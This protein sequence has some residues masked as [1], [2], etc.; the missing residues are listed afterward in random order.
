VDYRYNIRGW[1]K[2]INDVNSLGS[3]LFGFKIGYNEGA[4]ALYNGNISSTSWRTNNTDNSLKQYNYLYDALNRIKSGKD[5]TTNEQYS[6]QNVLY[7]KNG[8][9]T[10]LVRT[11]HLVENPL[12]GNT[13]H[14]GEMDNMY[15][16]YDAGNKLQRV[17]DVANKSYGFKDSSTNGTDYSYDQN[18]N[19][20]SDANKGISNITYNHLNLPIQV[21]MVDGNI[22]YIYDAVGLKLKKIVTNTAESS[23][24]NTEYAGNYIYE[25]GSL[26][27]FNTAEGYVED[28][29]SGGFDYIYQYKDHLGNIRLSY[30]DA[31]GNGV[32]AQ[33]EIREENNYYPFGLKHR[34]YNQYQGAARDHT[35]EYNGSELEESLGF[36]MMEM[37]MR[38]FDPALAR[39]VVLDPV[40][41]HSL[42]P[43]NSF[44]N[45]PIIFA[46]PSG[47]DSFFRSNFLNQKGGH[48][49]DKVFGGDSA[50]SEANNLTPE[51]N[52][53]SKTQEGESEVKDESVGDTDCDEEC[54]RK[55]QNELLFKFRL[56]KIKLLNAQL[57][58]ETEKVA[59]LRDKMMAF[60][61]MLTD[62]GVE[63]LATPEWWEVPL[64]LFGL[65]GIGKYK[66]FL[67]LL[68]LTNKT[69]KFFKFGGDEAI[70]HFGKHAEQIM[71]VTGRSSYNLKDY[72]GDANWII[73]NGTYSSKLN[74]YFYYMGNS[75]KSGE[76]LLGFVGMKYGG[77]T[78]STFHIKSA[79]KLGL[80]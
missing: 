77:N 24:T 56:Y 58:G 49:T 70:I 14:F 16:F 15:Y 41:H 47:A 61:G 35:F 60:G 5:N 45:N 39:W 10:R 32:I 26:Q 46:D 63:Q 36:N 25:N 52:E 66:H 1:L 6:L 68:Q 64:T 55:R 18:G 34:G 37:E 22:Q 29:G 3:D 78:I 21:T 11:G 33:S 73:K 74:G 59:L 4:N 44:D 27:F 54:Q 28:D 7:D 23:L 67:K 80:K 65:G 2:E 8:N 57:R 48:W 40:T 19:M 72:I 20:T 13:S 71:K 62:Q 53:F 12:A 17:N 30:S 42:S 51:N 76:S 38:Q 43:Y 75:A 50:P 69:N 31:D 79:T 9:I